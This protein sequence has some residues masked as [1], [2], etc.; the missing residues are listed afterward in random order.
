M[1]EN[2]TKLYGELLAKFSQVLG[3][4]RQQ[5]FLKIAGDQL[6]RSFNRFGAESLTFTVTKAKDVQQASAFDVRVDHKDHQG[7]GH[8]MYEVVDLELFVSNYGPAARVIEPYVK[9]FS[10]RR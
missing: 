3:P 8:D 4:Q 5:A 6:D 10:D 9:K 1:A 2:G 7:N